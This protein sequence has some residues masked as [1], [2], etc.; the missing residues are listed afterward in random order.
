[1]SPSAVRMD[2]LRGGGAPVL[3]THRSND[4]RDVVGRVLDARFDA[5][6]GIATLQ[7]S[8]ATDVEPLWQ[9]VADGML[10]SASVGYRVQHYIPIQDPVAGNIYRAVDWVPFEISVVPIPVETAATSPTAGQPPPRAA[11]LNT[12][13]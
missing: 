10:R 6:R 13:A 8:S 3:N 7:F 9:R 5:E 4:A 12:P 1:M 2:G 11:A